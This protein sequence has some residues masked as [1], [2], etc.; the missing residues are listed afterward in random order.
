VLRSHLT[1]TVALFCALGPASGTIPAREPSKPG[2]AKNQAASVPP[3]GA[4]VSRPATPGFKILNVEPSEA[5]IG[6]SI[7]VELS[8]FEPAWMAGEK[9]MTDKL[10][11]VL[12]N[13]ELKG[14][15]PIHLGDSHKLVFRLESS[16]DLSPV[17]ASLLAEPSSRTRVL[18]LSTR[19]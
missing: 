14:Q 3:V 17:R 2:S 5:E 12:D 7:T 19:P 9:L 8:G 11:L 4:S 1:L 18:P 16:P 10:A 13:L 15:R 6:K